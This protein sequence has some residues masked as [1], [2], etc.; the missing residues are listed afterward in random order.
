MPRLGSRVAPPAAM[1]RPILRLARLS[2]LATAVVAVAFALTIALT[3]WVI[4]PIEARSDALTKNA[5][6]SARHVSVARSDLDA[7]FAGVRSFMLADDAAQAEDAQ[8]RVWRSRKELEDEVVAYEALPQFPGEPQIAAELDHSLALLDEHLPEVLTSQ[9]DRDPSTLQSRFAIIVPRVDAVD[10]ALF[11]LQTLNIDNGLEQANTIKR[12]QDRAEIVGVGLSIVSLALALAAALLVRR[13]AHRQQRDAMLHEELLVARAN[14]LDAF[15]GRVAHDLKNPLAGLL[16]RL[17]ILRSRGGSLDEKG[18]AEHVDK[19]IAQVRRIDSTIEALLEFAHA[20][21]APTP[22]VHA[23]VRDT[24]LEAVAEV[25]PRAEVAN[26]AL[27]VDV[28]PVG[29]A[30]CPPGALLSVL[31]NLLDNAVKYVVEGASPQRKV[32]ARATRR[33]AFAHIEIEDTGPGIPASA[34]NAIF[35]PFVRLPGTR[36]PGTGLGLATV[37]RLVEAYHGVIGVRSVVGKSTVFWIDLPLERLTV[38]TRQDT[39]PAAF[40][41]PSAM[42]TSANPKPCTSS[43]C[44]ER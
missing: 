16:M 38:R 39:P 31:A 28:P 26:V 10:D 19:S 11:R 13:L 3:M 33:G 41:S 12:L 37:K 27:E 20:G 14:E 17:S 9:H 8:A 24:L 35:Q 42:S 7:L 15:A 21:A 23:S 18:V 4:G 22:G 34:Q 25:K 36:Q 30:A 1:D 32:T 2:A 6:P 29:D 43:R 40:R 5:L 44:S